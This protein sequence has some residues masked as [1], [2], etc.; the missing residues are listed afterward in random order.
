MLPF[1]LLLVGGGLRVAV[2]MVEKQTV[3]FAAQQGAAYGAGT[4]NPCPEAM[5]VGASVLGRPVGPGDSCW[6]ES[7]PPD[8]VRL[9]LAGTTWTMPLWGEVTVSGDAGAVV[10]P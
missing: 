5:A 8:I 9:T 3:T 7:G 1:V 10:A 4:S 2:A 6:V